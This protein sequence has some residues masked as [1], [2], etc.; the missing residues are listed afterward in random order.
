MVNKKLTIVLTLFVL[1]MFLAGCDGSREPSGD[2]STS[3][4]SGGQGR[5]FIGGDEG[6]DVRFMTG[7]PPREVYDTDYSFGINV[8]LEN[9]GEWDIKDA[10]EDGNV[11]AR[12]KVTGID[13]SD[14]GKTSSDLIKYSSD[15]LIGAH[16]DSEDNEID[17]VIT[18]ID[19]QDLK[20]SGEV[21]GQVEFIVR[22]D[23]CYEYGTKINSK[24]CILKDLIG[25]TRKSG[26]DPFCEPTEDKTRLTENSGAPV[27]V[28]SFKQSVMGTDKISVR[29]DIEHVGEGYI[30]KSNTDCQPTLEDK[31]K[32]KVI[33][34]AGLQDI[35][36]SGL[37]N[38]AQA[39]DK[40][41]YSGDIKL[42]GDQG[43]EI[44]TI[45]CTIPLPADGREDYE[46]QIT[47]TLK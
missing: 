28:T 12:M 1:I 44:N 40:E 6:I 37:Q 23:L 46:K 47:I 4:A 31:N 24:V 7:A 17:G 8:R 35:T 41:S 20:Y 39:T 13:P 9:V 45:L 16:L 38:G 33:V 43:S 25:K 10:D 3:T 14:F 19:F 34:D 32:I 5:S 42:H 18:N 21:T 30:Y 26:E 22:A 27:H 29:F 36:C 11:D 15:E 2:T